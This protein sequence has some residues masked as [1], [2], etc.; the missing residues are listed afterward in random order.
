MIIYPCSV[1]VGFPPLEG[2][3]GGGNQYKTELIRYRII[4][5]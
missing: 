4:N 1:L 3:K 2:D 5:R